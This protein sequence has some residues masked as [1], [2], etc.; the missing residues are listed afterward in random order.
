MGVCVAMPKGNYPTVEKMAKATIATFWATEFNDGMFDALTA[1]YD[2]SR[3][4]TNPKTW[5]KKT[6]NNPRWIPTARA[7]TEGESFRDFCRVGESLIHHE[8]DSSDYDDD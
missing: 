1:N 7:F 4:L 2:E 3:I 5:E 6:R 8:S